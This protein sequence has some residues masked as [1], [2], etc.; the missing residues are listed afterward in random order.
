LTKVL[1]SAGEASG[2]FYGAELA[3]QIKKLDGKAEVMGFGGPRMAAAGVDVRLD[4]VSHAVMGYWEAL[5]T[6]PAHLSNFSR[7]KSAISEIKPDVL[8]VIDSP[9]FHMPLIKE[10]RRLGAKKIIYYSTPQVWIW[11]YRRIFDIKKYA[12]LC[13]NVLPLRKPYLKNTG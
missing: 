2:D 10:A 7:A 13:I 5:K 11:K 8:V 12:D 1:I 4:L 3:G 6:L 9:S